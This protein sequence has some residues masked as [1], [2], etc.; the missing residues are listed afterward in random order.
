MAKICDFIPR[1]EGLRTPLRAADWKMMELP[2]WARNWVIG[3]YRSSDRL[4][5]SGAW[6]EVMASGGWPP[7][8]ITSYHAPPASMPGS[9]LVVDK[10]I[11]SAC[12]PGR[13]GRPARHEP[14]VSRSGAHRSTS[15]YDDANHKHLA[16]LLLNH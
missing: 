14:P 7:D 3:A 15:L 13:E 2:R 4:P 12:T 10:S 6:Y 16:E 1:P 5:P 8:A 9:G 11:G